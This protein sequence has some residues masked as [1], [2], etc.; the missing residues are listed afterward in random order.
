MSCLDCMRRNGNE[1]KI[2]SLISRISYV[3]LHVHG[4]Y[5]GRAGRNPSCAR[6]K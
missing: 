5:K 3:R 1:W 4:T 2:S 6:V